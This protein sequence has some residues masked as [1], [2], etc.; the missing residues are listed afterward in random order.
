MN[1][2]LRYQKNLQ[3]GA[4]PCM[5]STILDTNYKGTIDCLKEQINN[6]KSRL[7]RTNIKVSKVAES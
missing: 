5:S 4:G 3:I 1:K 6:L 7:E 2:T